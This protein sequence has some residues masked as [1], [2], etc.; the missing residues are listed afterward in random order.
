MYDKM[1]YNISHIFSRLYLLFAFL[2]A[3]MDTSYMKSQLMGMMKTFHSNHSEISFLG[4][5]MER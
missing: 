4:K 1:C 5:W 2:V 3:I